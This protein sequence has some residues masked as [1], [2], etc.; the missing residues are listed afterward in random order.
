[1]QDV[2]GMIYSLIAVSPILALCGLNVISVEV[3]SVLIIVIFVLLFAIRWKQL[4][5]D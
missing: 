5:V 2:V 3:S 4:G 1:M